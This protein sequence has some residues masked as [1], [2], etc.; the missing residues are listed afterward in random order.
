MEP[1]DSL[2]HSQNHATCPCPEPHQFI[3]FSPSDFLNIHLNII[4]PSTPGSSKWSLS[5]SFPPVY[6]PFPLLR[7]YQSISPSPRPFWMNHN[8]MRFD[9]EELLATSPTPKLEDHPLSTVRYCLFNIFADTLHT[10]GRSSTRNL[11][12]RHGVVTVTHLSWS[13][14]H[15]TFLFH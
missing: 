8:R 14:Q 2:P 1:E 12:T 7:S 3:P 5:L 6:T 10:G 13:A 9:G 15:N 11:T 4:L